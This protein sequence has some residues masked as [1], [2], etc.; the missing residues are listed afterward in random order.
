[1]NYH[2]YELVKDRGY[3]N[4]YCKINNVQKNEPET[5][6]LALKISKKCSIDN[7][8]PHPEISVPSPLQTPPAYHPNSEALNS[9]N[10]PSSDE[11]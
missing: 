10:T 5:L 6:N 11:V 7:S 3:T 4:N 2:L 9:T 1:V 8:V